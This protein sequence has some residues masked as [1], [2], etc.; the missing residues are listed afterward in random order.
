MPAAPVLAQD[1][2]PED[3][4]R[5]AVERFGQAYR[6]ADVGTLRG[7]LSPDYVHVNGGSG[8]RIDRDQWLS[9]VA[10]QKRLLDE[11]ELRIES[12]EVTDTR[13]QLHGNTAVVTGTVSSEGVRSGEPFRVNV[14]FTNVWV[15]EDGTW[16]RAAFHDSPIPESG[17]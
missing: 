16:R 4:V 8:S 14:R 5:A 2:S 9:W 3:E 11:G 7:M 12:Y 6:D 17:G 1:V 15:D 10:S 13:I